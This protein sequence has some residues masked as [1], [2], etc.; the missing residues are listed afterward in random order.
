MLDEDKIGEVPE[1]EI[2]LMRE[3]VRRFVRDMAYVIEKPEKGKKKVPKKS[4][5]SKPKKQRK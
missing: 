5:K 1:R 2:E 3:Y 4:I